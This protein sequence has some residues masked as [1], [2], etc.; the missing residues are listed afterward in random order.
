MALQ[1]FLRRLVIAMNKKSVTVLLGES[2]ESSESLVKGL[3]KQLNIEVYQCTDGIEAIRKSFE[4]NPDLIILDVTLPRLNAY[5]CTCIL[6]NDPFMKST[7]IIHMSS[8]TN[9]IEQYWSM[10]CGGDGYLQK[11]VNKMDLDKILARFISEG[12]AKHRLFEPVRMVPDLGDCSILTMAGNL[13][14]HKLLRATIMNE[15]NMI[16]ISVMPTKDLVMALMTIV[17][18]LYDFTIGA[19][20]LLFNDYGEFFFYQNAQVEQNR[21]DEFKKLILKHLQR[22]HKIS[23]NPKQIRQ[24][25]LHSTQVK[26]I[27]RNTNE[28]YI[29]T[30]EGAPVHSVLAFENIEFDK[31]KE[32]EQEI[33]DLALNLVQG[34]LEKKIFF[35]MSQEL[36][37]IDAATEG[38]SISFFMECLKREI[39]NAKRNGYPITLCT[40][41]I[42]N[43]RDITENLSAE[44]VHGLIRIIQNHILRVMRKSDIVARWEMA[45]FAFLFTHTTLENARIAHERFV[46]YIMKFLPRHLP[47]SA[48]LVVNTGISQF[49]PERDQEP[50]IFFAHAKPKETPEKGKSKDESN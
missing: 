50:G 14:E 29:H 21:L 30:K 6:K 32:N 5:Q 18:S 26:E 2:G 40:I 1:F 28:V 15:I 24:N 4:K 8:S 31:L 35:Q 37:I 44:E 19:A 27:S 41:V 10:V 47:S 38:Y 12:R 49:N 13:L 46:K 36:S 17:G 22:Q 3:L 33:L 39:E 34:V 43:F 42:S 9:P 23:L 7:T 25:L 11:P 48:E 20:L 16:D 45:S